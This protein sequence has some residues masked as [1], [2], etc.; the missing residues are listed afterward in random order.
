MS[1]QM[2]AEIWIG[3][4]IPARLVARLCTIIA[5]Q[6]VATDWGNG[7]FRP[8]TADDLLSACKDN[9]QGVRL[10]WLCDDQARWGEFE[11][12]ESFL[13]RHKIAY[14]RRSDGKWEFEPCLTEYRPPGRLLAFTTNNAGEVVVPVTKLTSLAEALSKTPK[15]PARATSGQYRRAVTAILRGLRNALPPQVPPLDP[16]EIVRRKPRSK[17]KQS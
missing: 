7:C 9:P 10:L 1:E 15:R 11:L 12:L 6:C 16:F 2:S 8:C 13:R 4:E 5:E 17:E 3:G 14:T